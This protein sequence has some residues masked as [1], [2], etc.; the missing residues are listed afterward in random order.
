MKQSN[1]E[2]EQET[3]SDLEVLKIKIPV[4]KLLKSHNMDGTKDVTVQELQSIDLEEVKVED[5]PTFSDENSNAGVFSPNHDGLLLCPE[6]KEDMPSTISPY[7][8]SLIACYCKLC[9]KKGSE[10]TIPV[11]R[12]GMDIC[13]LLTRE[14]KRNL[15]LKLAAIKG[16]PVTDINFRLILRQVCMLSAELNQLMFSKTYLEHS[17]IWD[18]F[19]RLLMADHLSVKKF[20]LLRAGEINPLSKVVT[21]SGSG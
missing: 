3:S 5:I 2:P 7:L 14:K 11:L 4:L 9:H 16:W 13:N 10:Y 6:C 20:S 8:A 18:A 15:A 12:M 17:F 19:K 21:K 1:K